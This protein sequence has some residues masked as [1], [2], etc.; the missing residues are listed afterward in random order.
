M[1]MMDHPWFE[2]AVI[3]ASVLSVALAVAALFG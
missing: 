1:P 2:P 3:G